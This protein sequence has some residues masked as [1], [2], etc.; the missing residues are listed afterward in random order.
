MAELQD[1]RYGWDFMAKLMGADLAGHSA[2]L[3]YA[4][5]VLQNQ[6]IDI[7][8]QH[9][10]EINDAIDRFARSINEHP[11][12]NL[13]VEQFKGY[14]AEEFAAGT[15]NVDALRKGSS[16][17]AFTLQDN[18]YGSVDIGTNFGKSYSLKYANYADKAESYQAVLNRDTRLPKYQGQELLIAPEQVEDAKAWAVRRAGK[19]MLTRPDVAA[20]HEY[21]KDHLVG[22][23]SDGEGVESQAL[24]IKESKEIAR[25]AKD[26]GFDPEKH[27]I[28]KETYLAEVRIDYLNQA[29]KAGLTAATI[30][31]ITQLVPE[32]YKAIYYLIKY[33]EIDVNQFKNPVGK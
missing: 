11:H 26:S 21:V 32:L 18:G 14:V 17:M 2:Y 8:N 16:H 10:Q 12:L 20:S 23:V 15:F 31:A 4:A 25:E 13:G 7:Q 3:D 29:V 22:T 9:L 24:S 5:N 6:Q 33:G 19:D 30:T 27:G 28:A 1:V